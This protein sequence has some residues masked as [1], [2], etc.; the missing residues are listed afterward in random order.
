MDAPIVA[1]PV[2]LDVDALRQLR[3]AARLGTSIHY[4]ESVDSTNT[5]ALGLA[6]DHAAEGTVVI[7]ETQ[8]KG[9][10]RLGRTWTSP[11]CRN[12]YISIILR[13]PLRA[14]AAPQ[15]ALVLGLATAEAVRAWT[16]GVTIKWPN[17]VLIGRRKVAGIL[18]E[19]AAD[20][21]RVRFVIAGIGVNLNSTAA[22]FAPELRDKAVSLSSAVDA[23]IDRVAFTDCLL[24]RLEERYDQFIR[25]G[26]G[27]IRPRWEQFS[28]LTGRQVQI[29][30]GG[31]RYDGVVTG[32]ADDGSLLLRDATTREIAVVVGD[33]TVVDGYK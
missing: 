22:D 10:G 7:A 33:V 15:T 19:M 31:E 17:D 5:V 2:P 25:E 26:F 29:N 28:C 9:R 20:D 4:F 12:L 1:W 8:T 27:A 24:S 13:P 21:D 23:A 16:P 18:A 11:P 3:A 32:I 6:T 14:T 30:G